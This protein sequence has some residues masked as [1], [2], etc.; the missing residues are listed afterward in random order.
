[1]PSRAVEERLVDI[2]SHI[3]LA[4]QFTEGL[5]IEEFAAT[6]QALLATIRCLEVISE[7]TRHIPAEI[8]SRHPALPWVQIAGSGNVYRHDY[9]VVRPD[10]ILTTVR[11]ALPELLTAVEAELGK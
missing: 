11:D 3:R 10:V 2:Q 4:Q 6:P 8:K 1:M 7:A 9:P 5:T